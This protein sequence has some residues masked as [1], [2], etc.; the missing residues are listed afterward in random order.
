MF[1]ILSHMDVGLVLLFFGASGIFLNKRNILIAV[2]C[3]ELMFYGLNFNMISISLFLDDL[4]G[5]I[6][7]LFILTLAAGESALAL[8]LI[9]VFFRVFFHILMYFE[10]V[11]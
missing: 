4:A 5:Q 9:V 10:L 8:A 11:G 6:F 3:I 7:S 2:I 1:S